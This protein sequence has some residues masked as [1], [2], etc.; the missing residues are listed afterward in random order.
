MSLARG[1]E[2]WYNILPGFKRHI[3]SFK[4]FKLQKTILLYAAIVTTA[5]VCQGRPIVADHNSAS[6]F[7]ST[8]QAAIEQAKA[9]LHIAY[10]HT[11]HG[12]Q[13]ITGMNGLVGFMNGLGYPTNLYAW[14]NG[15]TGGALDLRDTPFSGAQDLGNPNYTAWEQATR[16]Y[17][18]T[19]DANGR[20]STR[21]EVNVIIWS[22]CG[23]V[24][25]SE[26]N[27]NL[28]LNLM[29]GLEED[30]FNVYFVYMTGHLTGTGAAGNVNIR[31]NQIRN[32][33][34]ANDKILYDFADIESYDPDGLVN[35]M[36][37]L[38]N[39]NCDYDS[40]GN[41]SRDRNWALD[42]Q[43]SHTVNID[44]Y[45]CSAAHSQA[46]NGNRK[47][48]AA[49]WLWA[50]LAGWDDSCPDLVDPD[51]VDFRDFAVLANDWQLSGS[52]LAGDIDKSGKAD[53]NDLEILSGYWLQECH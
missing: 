35:Y 26:A 41:G 21:P 47:A 25:T 19:P 14:N 39:D 27:I 24:D 31:N 48:Y 22:W 3:R 10:G 44:W 23:Q 20:G 40:D 32:Y 37:L 29:N 50:R 12:S 52:D 36:V 46:L 49:W 45:N 30:Y 7:F 17:L 28:Y 8:P 4:V 15:G 38:A 18:G 16:N 53:V 9:T 1:M 43:G 2:I 6:A 51:T 11:S 13:V 42:W 33:C 5:A 34:I